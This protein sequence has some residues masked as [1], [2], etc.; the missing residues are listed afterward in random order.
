VFQFVISA[1]LII[2]STVIAKQMD[3][4][5]SKDLGFIKDQ[6]MII[7]LRTEVSK[8]IYQSLKTELNKTP[9]VIS[10]GASTYYPGI[11]N[12]SD[13][14]L[15]KEGSTIDNAPVVRMNGVDDN[16]IQTL[17]IKLAAG[18][19][20]SKDYPNDT[21][22]GIVLNEEAITKIGFSS[23]QEAVGKPVYTGAGGLDNSLEIVGVIKNFHFQD[24]HLPIAPY[25]FTLRSRP[26]YNYLLVHTNTTNFASFLAGMTSVWQKLN[27]TEP[28]EYNFLDEEFQKNYQAQDRLAA[29]V[30]Y[31]TIIAI[32]ISCLGL[33]GLAT[34]SAE[35][36]TKEI[37]IRKVLGASVS[38]LVL[39]ISKDFIKLVLIAI[40]LASPVAWWIMN[41]WLQDFAYRT[42][43]GWAVFVLSASIAC[44]IAFITVS[45]QAI[46]AAITNPVK[47][48]RTE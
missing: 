18:R 33:F 17:G 8:G 47:S 26:S 31:F 42:D 37:G 4:M 46:R 14:S 29:I 10:V 36:R 43:I 39:L 23:P 41:K 11:F 27:P 32:M 30:K 24:L 9:G 25:G 12:P 6:E 7:P 22:R 16:L 21:I 15:Y 5:R 38:N 40:V 45:T 2:A 34:F 19:L 1:V 35:Q 3:Y 44:I 48:L 13:R 20:F 28:F